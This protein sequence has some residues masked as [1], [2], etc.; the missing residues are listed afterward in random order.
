MAAMIRNNA[1]MIR[2]SQGLAALL[3][4]GCATGV[5]VQGHRGARG[6]APENTLP[7]FER[8]LALGVDVLELDVAVTRDGV[9]VVSHDPVL[10]PNLTRGPDGRWLEAGGP[11]IHELT[12]DELARYDVGRLKPGSGYAQGYPDQV[13]A[14]GARIPRLEEVYALARRTGDSRV[15]FNI[16]TKVSPLA[17]DETLA[18]EPFARALVAEIRRAGLARRATIQSFDWRTLQV[19]RR[20]AP[21]IATVYLT[22]RQGFLDNVCANHATSPASCSDSPW[23]AGYQLREYGSVP[24]MV[25]AA[26][27]DA[28]SPFFGDLDA[29]A[30]REAHAL[31]LRVV[32]WT[33]NDPAAAGKL[34]EMGV[35]GLIT[36]R[37]DRIIP[38]ARGR[39]A[40]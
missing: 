17:P 13:P 40:R 22:A 38:L 6:L 7:A 34:I 15:R 26:G 33:V 31:G 16:E 39:A 10:N 37:P 27:G 19:V 8:A 1:R 25:K 24:R 29:D 11:A 2:L 30:V 14:D 9:V 4:A 21:E 23:T 3:L 12:Y 20:E 32:A 28:W 36:D 5:E 35:D 18:P